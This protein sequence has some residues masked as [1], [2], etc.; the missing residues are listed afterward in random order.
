MNSK[1]LNLTFWFL[2]FK[3]EEIEFELLVFKIDIETQCSENL[4]NDLAPS[5]ETRYRKSMQQYLGVEC[6][7]YKVVF[8]LFKKAYFDLFHI[9]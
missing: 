7:I 8:I 9:K 1:Y 2:A 6:V 3:H 4:Q 5:I